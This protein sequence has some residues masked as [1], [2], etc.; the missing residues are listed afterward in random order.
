MPP[1]A[2]ARPRSANAFWMIPSCSSK[3]SGRRRRKPRRNGAEL[4]RDLEMVV[5][6]VNRAQRRLAAPLPRS[7]MTSNAKAARHQIDRIQRQ[8][9]R[10]DE[11]IQP[12]KKPHVEPSTTHH[13]SGTERAGSEQ[14]RDRAG[15]GGLPCGGAQSPARPTRRQCRNC[16]VPE[17]AEPYRQQ[18]LELFAQCKGNLVRVHEELVA[19]GAELSYTRR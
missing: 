16:I 8:L 6:I 7:W 2:K 19:G 17:K 14:T 10:I 4:L 5:A 18:I 3:R 13:D 11:E 1:G 12:E 9:H 15:A